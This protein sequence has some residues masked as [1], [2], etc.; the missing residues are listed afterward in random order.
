MP[1]PALATAGPGAAAIPAGR[2]LAVWAVSWIVGP[3]FVSGLVLA[4]VNGG[5]DDPSI[6][7]IIAGTVA[8]WI[9]FLAALGWVSARRI[10]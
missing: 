10:G 6:P 1:D 8:G 2:A 7:S 5:I 9:V 4:A 3:L